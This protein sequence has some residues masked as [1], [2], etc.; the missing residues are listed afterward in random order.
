MT[1]TLNLPIS[2][3]ISPYVPLS[4]PISTS[5]AA[6]SISRHL[7]ISPDISPLQV[8]Q[9]LNWSVRQA[10]ELESHLISPYLPISPDLS[11]RQATELESHLISVERGCSPTLPNHSFLKLANSFIKVQRASSVHRLLIHDLLNSVLNG[12]RW[13]GCKRTRPT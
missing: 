6:D 12:T 2:P 8:T 11:P 1:Q 4:P 5:G 13:S 3:H 7:P 9:T 10:T